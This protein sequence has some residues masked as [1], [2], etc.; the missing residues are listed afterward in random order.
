M[1]RFQSK[2]A[3]I[4]GAARGMGFE[5][6]NQI[7][8]EGGSV[9][10]WDFDQDGL[11]SALDKLSSKGN[12]LGL[13]VD[14]SNLE[15]VEAA[16][17]DTAEKLGGVDILVTSAGIAGPNALVE[18]FPAEWWHRVMAVNLGGVFNCCRSVVPYMREK[19]YG[20]IVNVASVAGKEGNPNASAY[21]ASKAG[22]LSLTKSLG[23]ELATTG[24][25][26]NA[27]TPAV[28]KT[29]ML[30]DVTEQQISYMLAKIPMGRMGTV[31]EVAKMALFLASEDCSYSTAAVFDMTGGRA[32]Y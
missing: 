15:N 24:I 29:E 13:K 5:I 23:K 32:T 9:S 17:K 22:V 31:E 6:A 10:L 19:N 26:V 1:S 27:I 2:S 12:V 4:T 8:E 20:R 28:I 25:C 14:V 3:V 21:S 18:E 16:A 7:L 11:N 30:K